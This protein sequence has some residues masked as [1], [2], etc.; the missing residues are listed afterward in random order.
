MARCCIRS[1]KKPQSWKAPLSGNKTREAATEDDTRI[2]D[3]AQRSPAG[4]KGLA[5]RTDIGALTLCRSISLSQERAFLIFTSAQQ[6]GLIWP[7]F[8]DEESESFSPRR[9]QRGEV[10]ELEVSALSQR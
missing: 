10:V 8:P 2:S 9:S 5:C 3:P 1:S 6:R 4:S 7:H